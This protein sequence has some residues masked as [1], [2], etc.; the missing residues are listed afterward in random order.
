MPGIN[1]L[2]NAHKG[3]FEING[4]KLRSGESISFVSQQTQKLLDSVPLT[5]KYAPNESNCYFSYKS[6]S[7]AV[8]HENQSDFSRNNSKGFDSRR[9]NESY[10]E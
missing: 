2:Q 6:S 9:R 8:F 5:V 7:T 10:S 3:L 4:G 1:L